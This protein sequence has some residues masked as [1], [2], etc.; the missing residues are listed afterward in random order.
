MRNAG[1]GSW[2]ERRLRISPDRDALWFEGT[3]TSHAG[4]AERVRRTAG[5]LAGL[6]VRAGDRVAW[7]GGN[8]PSALETLFACGQLGA[9]WVPVNARL[10]VPEAQ[11]V[12][13]HSGA[14][15]VVHGGDHGPLADAL[16]DRL[17]EVRRWIAAEP[18]GND[19]LPY[20]DLLAAADAE[21]RDEPVG[22]DDPCLVMYTS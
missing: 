15:V 7:T 19:S 14:G 17:P 9:I 22:L 12:L 16:R 8:H 11:F 6:G 4:F 3:T 13:T 21:P 10:T 18:A 2:P 20:E 1:L 5:A